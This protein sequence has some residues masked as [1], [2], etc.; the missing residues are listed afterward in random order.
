MGSLGRRLDRLE[1]SFGPPEAEL[2]GQSAMDRAIQQAPLE[3][4]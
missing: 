2:P 1:K 4:L 3:V